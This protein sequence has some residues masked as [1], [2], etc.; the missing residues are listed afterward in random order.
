MV[1]N[2]GLGQ[3]TYLPEGALSWLSLQNSYA[4]F[5]A[6]IQQYS[7]VSNLMDSLHSREFDMGKLSC[8]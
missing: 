6:E 1:A 5:I 3:E 7:T 2:G 8:Q 4:T